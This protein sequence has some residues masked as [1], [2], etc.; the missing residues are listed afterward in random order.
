MPDQPGQKAV[1]AGAVDRGRQAYHRGADPPVRKREGR[2]RIRQPPTDMPH[3]G[4]LLG[5]VTVLFGGQ[6]T[7]RQ[8]QRSGGDQ[9]GRAGSG[10]CRAERLDG[11]TI[12]PQG[13]TGPAGG[14]CPG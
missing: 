14:G 5:I 1:V 8:P 7:G 6:L 2:L 12:R 13:S 9:E 10:Q 4:Y 11:P 3:P